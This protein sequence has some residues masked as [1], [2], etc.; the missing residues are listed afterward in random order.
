MFKENK[1]IND[2]KVNNE[3]SQYCY[4]QTSVFLAQICCP[5]GADMPSGPFGADM[6]SV[7]QC[8]INSSL[9][10][11]MRLLTLQMLTFIYWRS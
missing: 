8:K 11:T 1:F 9:E 3:F 4:C 6:L 10:G 2:S 5:F 7:V